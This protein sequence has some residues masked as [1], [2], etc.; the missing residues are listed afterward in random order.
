MA[1][2]RRGDARAKAALWIFCL[3]A[4]AAVFTKTGSG[5]PTADEA[6]P[7]AGA[8]TEAGEA[9]EFKYFEFLTDPK[10]SMTER[11]ALFVTLAV[12]IAGLVYAAMLMQQV[13]AA[14]QGTPRM[15]AVAAA[16][17]EGANAYLKRQLT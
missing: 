1:R 17:R 2:K 12:A 6:P 10:Y 13:K 16:V 15:Q 4:A 11:V 5:Q 3:I 7:A 14:D 8:T 9:A